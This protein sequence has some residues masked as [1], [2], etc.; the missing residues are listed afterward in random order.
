MLGLLCP[1][2]VWA[3]NPPAPPQ[4]DAGVVV[5]LGLLAVNG[6]VLGVLVGNEDPTWRTA[7]DITGAIA[8][9]TAMVWAASQLQ[10]PQTTTSLFSPLTF[11]VG[12]LAL[13]GVAADLLWRLW[14]GPTFF[15]PQAEAVNVRL[16]LLG[17]ETPGFLFEV[18]F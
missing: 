12:A 2:A 11:V 6:A 18:R 3:Q 14:L 8:G 4:A 16:G 1:I 17:I 13:V 10:P 7:A 9:P 5:S 15:A